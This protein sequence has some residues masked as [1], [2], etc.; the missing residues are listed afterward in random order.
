MSA[1]ATVPAVATLIDLP[2]LVGA[3][4]AVLEPITA[5]HV[6]AIK[7]MQDDINTKHKENQDLRHKQRNDF[8]EALGSQYLEILAA[9]ERV[10]KLEIEVKRAVGVDGEG[11]A[12]RALQDGQATQLDTSKRIE[13]SVNKLR[14]VVDK[15]T[16]TIEAIESKEASSKS[17]RE[18]RDNYKEWAE[19]VLKYGS[20]LASGIYVAKHI[21]W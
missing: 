6:G 5:A 12:I 8:D 20:L 11:G 16:P 2:T 4:N 18:Q 7:S 13:E 1:L 10:L 15:W 21:K 3:L 14:E 17:I 19:F 9:K